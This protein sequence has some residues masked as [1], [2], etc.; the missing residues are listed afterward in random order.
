MERPPTPFAPSKVTSP[1]TTKDQRQ[2]EE[3]M[4]VRG[5][6]GRFLEGDCWVEFSK[7]EWEFTR[8]TA[9]L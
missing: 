5:S 1:Y 9:D 4:R 8:Q 6:Q 7:A 3:K 2:L